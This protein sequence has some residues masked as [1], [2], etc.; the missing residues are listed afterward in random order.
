MNLAKTQEQI[1]RH[2]GGDGA[3]ARERITQTYARRHDQDFWQFWQAQMQ[4]VINPQDTLVDL[5]AGI[6]QFVQDLALRYPQNPII[7][8]EVAPY[9]LEH[10]LNLADNALI[11][12]VD[13]NDPQWDAL[14]PES[15]ACIMANMLVH[16]LPQP[17]KLIQAMMHW[18]KPGGRICIIDLVRQP[19]A[20]YL[21][22]KYPQAQLQD[23][24]TSR[25]ALEDAFEHFLEHNRYTLADLTYLFTQAGLVLLETTPLSQGRMTRLVLQ[26]PN[27]F[28]PQPA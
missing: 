11:Q 26:K 10:Q 15:V 25:A 22:H 1:L 19:L 8:I 24:N 3:W 6:G 9:M 7:G 13:L 5:G 14:R 18:L 2:H 17:I 4:P 16:E 27:A 21:Q 20:D 23:P 12:A 28:H